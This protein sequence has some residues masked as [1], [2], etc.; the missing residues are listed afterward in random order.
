MKT[1]IS[2]KDKLA[3][4]G[5]YVFAFYERF[6]GSVVSATQIHRETGM[7]MDCFIEFLSPSQCL[8]MY[9]E[10]PVT[11]TYEFDGEWI[12]VIDEEDGE[13]ELGFEDNKIIQF[14]TSYDEDTQEERVEKMYYK[15]AGA[16]D[17]QMLTGK[18]LFSCIEKPD[19]KVVTA[20]QIEEV[21]LEMECYIEFPGANQCVLVFNDEPIKGTYEFDGKFITFIEEDGAES[22]LRYD[23]NKVVLLRRYN[24]EGSDEELVEKQYY[25]KQSF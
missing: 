2:K 21:G 7:D 8:L 15:K 16:G 20:A 25:E 5:K 13:L 10:E 14:N 3:L 19:G 23:D 12:T 18:Y 6:D 17:S 11:G 9:G 4:M 24:A 22:I 1:M